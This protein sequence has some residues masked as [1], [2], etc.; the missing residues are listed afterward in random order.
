MSRYIDA[1]EVIKGFNCENLESQFSERDIVDLIESRPTENVIKVIRCEDCKHSNY[2][3]DVHTNNY[4]QSVIAKVFCRIWQDWT[5]STGYC[6][7]ADMKGEKIN[8]R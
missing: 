4:G 1:D 3:I 7:L 8:D 5:P 6:F 2:F